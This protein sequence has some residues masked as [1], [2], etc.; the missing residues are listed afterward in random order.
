MIHCLRS[1]CQLT[2]CTP[3]NSTSNTGTALGGFSGP[4]TNVNQVTVTDTIVVEAQKFYHVRIS[5]P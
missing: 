2:Y 1:C 3:S 5:F 4:I